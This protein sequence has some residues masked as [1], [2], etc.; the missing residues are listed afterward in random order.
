MLPAFLDLHPDAHVEVLIDYAYRDIIAD[1]FDAGIRLGEKLERDMMALKIG[2]DLRSTDS[3]TPASS[4]R[5]LAGKAS[6][7]VASTALGREN[8]RTSRHK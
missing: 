8:S 4:R 6:H 7:F 3:T 5:L 1:G 2:P